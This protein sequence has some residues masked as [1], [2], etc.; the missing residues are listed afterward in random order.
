MLSSC[1]ELSPCFNDGN[2]GRPR[3][4]PSATLSK[5]PYSVLQLDS[6]AARNKALPPTR[7]WLVSGRLERAAV[8]LS[9]TML[10]GAH[11]ATAQRPAR[12]VL[13]DDEGNGESNGST[14]IAFA[15]RQ[16][17]PVTALQLHTFTPFAWP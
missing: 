15:I 16:S 6:Q 13:Q 5:R 8:W 3:Q 10:Q 9:T 4:Q 1:R 2:L 12:W 14:S 7:P 11:W 17:S